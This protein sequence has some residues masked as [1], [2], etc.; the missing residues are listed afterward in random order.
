MPEPKTDDGFY[1]IGEVSTLSGLS[2]HTIRVWERRYGFP[3]AERLPS[4]HRRYA[5]SQVA[6]VQYA[7]E[8]VASG[9]RPGKILSLPAE[10]LQALAEKE[11]QTNLGGPSSE[12][13]GILTG[14]YATLRRH[15]DHQFQEHGI[16]ITV[17]DFVVPLIKRIG[18]AWATNEIDI[19]R[20]H[21]LSESIQD[22]LRSARLQILRGQ[23]DDRPVD[24]ILTTLPGEQHGLGLQMLSL[25][26]VLGGSHPLLL[27]VDLPIEEIASAATE[28]VGAAIALSISSASDVTTTSKNLRRLRKSLPAET[29]MIVGGDGLP[30]RSPIPGVTPIRDLKEFEQWLED[31]LG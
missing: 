10:E 5:K 20:E 26:A 29:E 14:P 2:P 18:Q 17:H 16:R 8:L 1:A 27:G 25:L 21:L 12:L 24:L 31:R 30:Q 23:A 15:L 6:L 11:R 22:A 13:D 4:G 7:A 28:N 3:Q 9:H 19:H